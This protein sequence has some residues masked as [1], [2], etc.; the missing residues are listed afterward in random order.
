M[1]PRPSLVRR[2]GRRAALL[3][4]AALLL[5][6]GLSAQENGYVDSVA[7]ASCHGRIY[8]E[9]SKTPMGRSFFLPGTREVKEDWTHNNTFYHEPSKRH[10]EMVRRD[11]GFFVRRYQLDDNG[12]QIHLIEK[13]IT[14]VMGSGER[15]LSYI[16]RSDDGRMVELPV[17][18][19]SQEERWAMAPGYDRPN[20]KG[21]SRAI[22]NKCM[23]CQRLSVRDAERGPPGVGPRSPLPRPPAT[24]HRLPALPWARGAACERGP[25]SDLVGQDPSVN[26][27]PCGPQ[28]RAAA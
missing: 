12:R 15:A 18:W 27:E 26:S 21:F 8:E 14:H 6:V 28:P 19:Y 9:F 22:T 24:G 25:R 11:G 10:Y 13:Q 7:C 17:S 4:L 23:F 20:H 3:Q 2:I 5:V 16:H 1:R